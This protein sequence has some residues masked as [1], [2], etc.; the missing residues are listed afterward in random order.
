MS[1]PQAPGGL[2]QTIL[3]ATD[4]SARCDRAHARAVQLARQWNADLIV[5]HVLEGEASKLRDVDEDTV[6][7]QLL[8]ELPGGEI[9]CRFIVTKGSASETILHK[10]CE[11][12]ADLIITGVAHYDALG[13]FIL[14]TTVDQ[15]VRKA[16]APVLVVKRRPLG[17]Y[18]AIAVG[19]DFSP[20]SRYA[21]EVATT[22]FPSKKLNVVH[23]YH[24]PFE[25]FIDRDV[26]GE[27]WKKN[28]Q[29]DFETFLHK[30]PLM[31][32]RRSDLNLILDDGPVTEVVTRHAREK[33][34]DLVAVGTHG[35]GLKHALLGSA[36]EALL[37]ALPCDVLLVHPPR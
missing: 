1:E 36:A 27:A 10:A 32:E 35:R 28:V 30:A 21:L 2:P 13:D 17:A 24:V 25:G 6:K 18:E 12:Q 14:G 16:T 29:R 23:A 5:L 22:L 37:S 31:L 4:L 15:V 3:L 8:A 19:V 11:L 34:F 20:C 33:K 7:A 26:A 9:R